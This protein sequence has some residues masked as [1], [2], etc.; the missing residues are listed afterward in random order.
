MLAAAEEVLELVTV[1]AGSRATYPEEQE[2]QV[3]A[4]RQVEQPVGQVLPAQTSLA[5]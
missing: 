1:V 3:L 2:R 4:S 5:R